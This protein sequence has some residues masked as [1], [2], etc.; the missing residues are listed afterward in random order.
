LCGE[1]NGRR[2]H[3][4]RYPYGENHPNAKLSTDDVQEIR[5]MRSGG[6]ILR[7]I[8]SKFHVSETLVSSIFRGKARIR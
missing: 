5:A 2:L 1:R 6:V 7:V 3:P 8:A 4:E